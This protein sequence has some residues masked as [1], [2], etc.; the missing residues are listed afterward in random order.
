MAGSRGWGAVTHDRRIRYKP[1]ELAAVLEHQVAQKLTKTT[2]PRR[3]HGATS[4]NVNS[5][6]CCC[7]PHNAELFSKISTGAPL[8]S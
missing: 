2:F 4:K 1:N 5:F 3:L 8:A 7:A 6:S